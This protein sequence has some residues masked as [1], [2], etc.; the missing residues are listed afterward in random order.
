[1]GRKSY[2]AA[3]TK[4]LGP[5][6]FARGG[7]WWSRTVGTVLEQVDL[8]RSSVAGRG[9][10]VNLWSKDLETERIL[11]G[12][13]CERLV[14]IMSGGKRISGLIPSFNGYDRWWVNNPN[15]PVELAEAVRAHGLPGLRLSDRL[16]TKLKATDE[17]D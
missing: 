11:H 1:M 15:G 4:V 8:Q 5:E 16:K 10:T 17:E 13:E 9:V 14:H 3:L 6:G 12:I 2:G 7:Q